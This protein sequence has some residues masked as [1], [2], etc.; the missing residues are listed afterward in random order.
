MSEQA[1]DFHLQM[2]D[3]HEQQLFERQQEQEIEMKIKKEKEKGKGRNKMPKF[4]VQHLGFPVAN[5]VVDES[6]WKELSTHKTWTAAFKRINKE[7]AHLQPGTWD[8]HYRVI[9]PDGS[10]VDKQLWLE[11]LADKSCQRDLKRNL[12]R[13]W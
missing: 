4:K 3:D 9:A 12:R 6:E 2:A 1:L 10:V 7:R 13:G 8:D 11:H 5:R